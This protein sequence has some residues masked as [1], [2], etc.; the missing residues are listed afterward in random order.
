VIYGAK[1]ANHGQF[2]VNLDGNELSYSSYASPEVF[3]QALVTNTSLSLGYHNLTVNNG[4]VNGQ[5]LDIDWIDIITGDGCVIL[6]QTG[7]RSY[8]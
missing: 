6:T 8:D 7:S 2:S 5:W 4:A 3:Q 1:R